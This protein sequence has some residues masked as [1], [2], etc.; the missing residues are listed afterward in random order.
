MQVFWPRGYEA[1]SLQDLL[2]A[3]GLTQGSLYRATFWT[4]RS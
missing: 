3:T 2:A 1:T 4:A